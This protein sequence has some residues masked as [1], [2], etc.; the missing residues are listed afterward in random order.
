MIHHPYDNI[1]DPSETSSN[2]GISV[3]WAAN[4]INIKNQTI[5]HQRRK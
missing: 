1:S 4:S 5:I 2:D 3:N